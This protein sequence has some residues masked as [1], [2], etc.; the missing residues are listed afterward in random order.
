METGNSDIDARRHWDMSA[1]LRR[2]GLRPTRQRVGLA[3]LL[4]AG[5][6][7]HVRAE[8]LS[9]EARAA[10]L[11]VSLATV[12]NTLH[13]FVDAGLLRRVDVE[14]GRACFD[15]NLSPHHHFHDVGTN[16]LIDFE[17]ASVAITGLPAAPDGK[18]VTHIDL[19]V[20]VR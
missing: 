9:R 20:R 17:A 7:R 11:R 15:T 6:D 1:Q 16:E 4:F 5:P 8:E 10:G 12:Y 14:P 13:Q 2:A 19:V 3:R 18:T